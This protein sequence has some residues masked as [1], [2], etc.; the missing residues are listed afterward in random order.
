M[1]FFGVPGDS[2]SAMIENSSILWQKKNIKYAKEKN[3][4]V[5]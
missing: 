2:A 3:K 5:L 1:I 4:Y